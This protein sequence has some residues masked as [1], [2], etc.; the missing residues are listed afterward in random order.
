MAE[1]PIPR[2]GNFQNHANIA[3]NSEGA[4]NNP[5][6]QSISQ[7]VQSKRRP[8]LYLAKPY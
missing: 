4:L 1:Q 6:P 3:V 2:E 8:V 7:T 5:N